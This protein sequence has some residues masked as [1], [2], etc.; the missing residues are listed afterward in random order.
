MLFLKTFKDVK[1]TVDG[2]AFQTFITVNEK[3]LSDASC[4]SSM[5]LY[6]FIIGQASLH[7]M[8]FTVM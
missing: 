3:L 4:A 1:F 2:S 6:A 7:V 5:F 8:Y